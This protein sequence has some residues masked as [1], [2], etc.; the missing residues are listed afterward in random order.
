MRIKRKATSDKP[1]LPAS[2][3]LTTFNDLVTL[4]MVFFVLIFSMSVID[5]HKVKQ[6]QSALQSGLGVLN[7]GDSAA[8]A[9]VDDRYQQPA[10][11]AQQSAR[12]KKLET[13]IRQLEELDGVSATFERGGITISMD[14]QLLF[15]PGR[16]R[17]NPGSR[18]QLDRVARVLRK[19]GGPVRVEG[20]TD[21]IP[22]HSR[23]F[24]SNWE[25]STARAVRVLKYLADS[26]RIAPQ[27]L[28]AVGYGAAKPIVGN[29]TP[30]RR[31]INRRVEIILVTED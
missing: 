9:V 1:C 23:R 25:L 7:A 19:T 13:S 10:Q 31:A 4:L 12:V 29:D 3:W 8:V 17:L 14:E 27:R 15:A 28:S 5:V 30:D 26:G 22:V 11:A 6:F 2:G 20:H 21:N 24:P 16:A 18:A